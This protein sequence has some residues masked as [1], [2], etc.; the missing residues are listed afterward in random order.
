MK[1]LN[2]VII[3]CGV[4]G[5]NFIRLIKE[6]N[7]FE[8][9]GICD[10]S[11]ARLDELTLQYPEIINKSTDYNDFI[12]IDEVDAAF[13]ITHTSTHFDIVKCYLE[14]GKHVFCEKPLARTSK[15][16]TKLKAI[17]EDNDR[18]LLVGHT[19]LYNQGIRY[20]KHYLQNEWDD[21]LMYVQLDRLS[22]GPFR[23]DVNVLYDFGV[24][25]LSILHYLF[26]RK[27]VSVSAKGVGNIGKGNADVVFIEADMGEDV[28]VHIHLSRVDATKV[29]QVKLV[30]EKTLVL[31]DD[32]IEQDKVKVYKKRHP[33]DKSITIETPE[34]KFYEPLKYVVNH[35][36][37]C[38]AKNIRPYSELREVVEVIELLEAV[39]ESL[40]QKGK[41]INLNE[42]K[43][44]TA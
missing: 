25:D 42:F 41:T 17:A 1:K 21:K 15:D 34:V 44:A 18:V 11:Q 37:D 33:Q 29:R 30:G 8:L 19:F 20:L 12:A 9:Y 16:A 24:H 26:G 40:N 31:F 7:T 35:F 36:Y 4:W 39:Q 28:L 3:G 43:T 10:A 27:P 6:S 5:S 22:N 2:V 38:V 32:T 23:D 14:S 13:V